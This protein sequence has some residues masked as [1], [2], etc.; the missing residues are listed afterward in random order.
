MI[1]LS[2]APNPRCRSHAAWL[3]MSALLWLGSLSTAQN[4]IPGSGDPRTYKYYPG[5]VLALGLGFNPSDLGEPKKPCIIVN[6]RSLDPG[7]PSTR[8]VAYY[9]RD[10]ND[11]SFAANLDAKAEAS[12]LG[13]GAS[14]HLNVDVSDVFNENSINVVLNATTDYG[15]WGLKPPV[16]LTTDAQALLRNPHK[17]AE[18]CGTRYVAIEQRASAVGVLI[19]IS[20]VREDIKN[21]FEADVQAHGGI[22]VVSASGSAKFSAEVKRG[23]KQNRVKLQVFATGG[24]GLSSLSGLVNGLAGQDDPMQ[25]L[26]VG[27]SG[28]LDKFTKDN[29]AVYSFTVASM[30]QF[31]LDEGAI[32]PW[33]DLKES[34]LREL[35]E[36]YRETTVELANAENYLAHGVWYDA[37]GAGLE[38]EITNAVPRLRQYHVELAV[39]HKKCKDSLDRPTCDMPV[40]HGALMP[41][42]LPPAAPSLSFKVR[43]H[44]AASASD[45]WGHYPPIKGSLARAILSTKPNEQQRF[46]KLQVPDAE[47]FTGEYDIDGGFPF[48]DTEQFIFVDEN[49][50]QHSVTLLRSVGNHS[51][52][53]WTDIPSTALT[54][55][56]EYIPEHILI[57][58]LRQLDG[59]H[60][61]TFY[62]ELKDKIGR[63]FR[64]PIF[65]VHWTSVAGSIQSY[66]A[67]YQYR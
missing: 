42:L 29:A 62:L 34:Q 11:F 66:E 32:D 57:Q 14:A 6:E 7:A 39:A 25:A 60:T 46:A 16:E 20:S 28:F 21:S 13:E 47:S 35:S 3:T 43:P 36:A 33:T 45:F 10:A 61:G 17:F 23:L 40:S 27:L 24:L 49:G 9:V 37:V 65:D 48:L 58:W 12:A 54:D 30:A 41:I 4:I 52:G 59:D 64:L 56:S 63:S 22:G 55:A 51:G 50:T 67:S 15:R 8:L 5:T 38:A 18:T 53:T 19:S 26:S 44:P 31:G 1:R 2:K